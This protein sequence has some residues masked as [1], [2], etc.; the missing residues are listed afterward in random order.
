MIEPSREFLRLVHPRRGHAIDLE[1]RWARHPLVARVARRIVCG[2]FA[3]PALV[4]T[5]RVAEDGSF[6]GD[7]DQ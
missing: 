6:A 1:R 2:V 4:E 5:F 3:G 7:D